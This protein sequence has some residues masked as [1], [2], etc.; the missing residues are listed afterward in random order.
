MTLEET[1]RLY[2]DMERLVIKGMDNRIKMVYNKE[3]IPLNLLFKLTYH[4]YL[5]DN[6]D[7][8]V[9]MRV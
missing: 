9:K 3:E 7:L 2:P 1:I 5:N 8:D 6:G 4:T